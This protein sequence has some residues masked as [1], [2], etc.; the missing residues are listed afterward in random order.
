MNRLMQLLFIV[1]LT[2]A[3]SSTVYADCGNC[4]G[5]GHAHGEA[6]EHHSHGDKTEKAA[7]CGCAKAKDGG[8]AW[9]GGCKVGHHDGKKYTCQDCFKK[10][11]GETEK[12]CD[13]CASKKKAEEKG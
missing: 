9:C 5:E 4:E 13:S 7:E 10:A 1:L 12:D 8:T 3:T 2:F 11:S 6:G